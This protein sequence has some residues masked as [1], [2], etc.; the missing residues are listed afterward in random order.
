MSPDAQLVAIRAVMDAVSKPGTR[1]EIFQE[2]TEGPFV[3][4][5]REFILGPRRIVI[6]ES[7]IGSPSGG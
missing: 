7:S 3:K 1:V 6:E 2:Q 4:G 5:A